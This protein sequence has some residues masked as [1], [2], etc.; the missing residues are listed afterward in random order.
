[1]SLLHQL[2]HATLVLFA[3][4]SAGCHAATTIT[5]D[6]WTIP[7]TG[8][9]FPERSVQVGD[10]I[11]WR[12]PESELHNVVYHPNGSCSDNHAV[13]I[14]PLS[15]GPGS[16]TFTESDSSRSPM[17]FLCDVD[18]R[19]ERG[20]QVLVNIVTTSCNDGNDNIACAE[21]ST[22]ALT[23]GDET[24]SPTAEPATDAP[25]RQPTPPPVPIPT[26]LGNI[27]TPS[28]NDGSD[29]IACAEA[30]TKV[31]TTAAGTPSP[32]PEPVADAPTRRP[33]PSPVRTPTP[34][35]TPLPTFAASTGRPTATA[36]PTV[37]VPT[38]SPTLRPTTQ[39][40][41]PEPTPPPTPTPT[42]LPSSPPVPTARPTPRPDPTTPSPTIQ[43]TISIA[44]I[45]LE[46]TYLANVST[47]DPTPFGNETLFDDDP[48]ANDDDEGEELIEQ[49]VQEVQGLVFFS[50]V[51]PDGIRESIPFE[52]YRSDLIQAVGLLAEQVKDGIKDLINQQRS[53]LRKQRQNRELE[54]ETQE[55]TVEFDELKVSDITI[56]NVERK[57]F[58]ANPDQSSLG[59][60]LGGDCPNQSGDALFDRC[61]EVTAS[62]SLLVGSGFEIQV[63]EEAFQNALDLGVESGRL[64]FYTRTESPDSLAN[65]L[66]GIVVE[67]MGEGSSNVEESSGGDGNDPALI[68]IIVGIFFAIFLMLVVTV[69]IFYLCRQRA[70]V[71]DTAAL[72]E[73]KEQSGPQSPSQIHSGVDEQAIFVDGV[74]M[75]S[76]TLFS[77]SQY[78]VSSRE[79]SLPM[80][81]D[82]ID[83]MSAMTGSVPASEDYMG[84]N[85]NMS[86][87]TGSVVRTLGDMMGND[88]MSFMEAASVLPSED[89]M[90]NDN[91]SYMEAQSVLP[92]EDVMGD[93]NESFM[94]PPSV[95]PSEDVL[96]H[97]NMSL[98][99]GSQDEFGMHFSLSVG[100]ISTSTAHKSESH[101]VDKPESITNDQVP[102][103][104]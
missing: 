8:N 66:S 88:D 43:P 98:M 39:A 92:S 21:A 81:D 99:S 72:G 17:L 40:P 53:L 95:L 49:P 78:N 50:L 65:I 24:P 15:A 54:E 48:P 41:V 26:A 62:V 90:S 87:M 56:V 104:P 55:M 1:M 44:P 71:V 19:C 96:G 59:S 35:P 37:P 101:T 7:A 30:S 9:P 38:A 16:Y 77:A 28:C 52:A 93:D 22:Q 94:A 82:L 86:F 29:N 45:S 89:V 75:A 85:D 34:R 69:S 63:V 51:V 27:V 3:C 14:Q 33:T 97:D 102:L 67:N 70:A 74:R 11:I 73:E 4:I 10:T 91:M 100:S 42:P 46:P 36:S 47:A 83:N 31:P 2:S 103:D 64:E 57:G 84:S 5:I 68:G 6:D 58:T 76:P 60:F 80:S 20:L 25:T 23:T 61:E 32:T 12:W 18:S 13:L 79:F